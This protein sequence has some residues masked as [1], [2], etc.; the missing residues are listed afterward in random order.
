MNE[1]VENVVSF[2]DQQLKLGTKCS[3][4]YPMRFQ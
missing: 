3:K 4:M 2:G 1:M